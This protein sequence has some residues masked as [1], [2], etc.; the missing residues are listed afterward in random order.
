MLPTF[1]GFTLYALLMDLAYA[2]LFLMLA[3]FL[4]KA[5]KILQNLY[6]P[7]SLL[8]GV[9][10]LLC[11]PQ[12]LGLIQYSS[13]VSG[14]AGMLVILLFA[15][16]TLGYKGAREGSLVNQVLKVKDTFCAHLTAG[17]LQYGLGTLIGLLLVTLIWTDLNPAIGIL[18][19]AGFAG[20]HG[21]AASIGAIL[22]EAGFNGAT[23]L[24]IT[25]AT[26]GLLCGIVIGMININIAIRLRST[27]YT[28]QLHEIPEEMRTG[29]IPEGMRASLG[30]ATMSPS[31]IDPQGWHWC[32]VFL[33]GG[34]GYILNLRI[35]KIGGAGGVSL[36]AMCWAA[37]VGFIIQ[38]MLNKAN[39][40][41]YVNK[42][43]INRVGATVTDFLVFFGMVS[44]DTSIIV[45]FAGPLIVLSLFGILWTL[46]VLWIL[47]PM[48]FT[49]NWFE[50]SIYIYGMMNG[51]IATGVTLMRVIDPDQQSG[52]LE[53]YSI[54][55]VPMSWQN[56]IQV[57]V[58]PVLCASGMVLQA[59]LLGVGIGVAAIILSIATHTM[60]PWKRKYLNAEV[61]NQEMIEQKYQYSSSAS[62]ST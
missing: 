20:G 43:A 27:R 13:V 46:F 41:S 47:G 4:R 3:Q 60:H 2:S 45:A 55:Y 18:L 61:F 10:G 14:Y 17:F 59:G 52:T 44:V 38:A 25:F 26:I 34:I 15:T 49:K 24:G 57:G 23:G 51:V 62:K 48:M 32:L 1:E 58:M 16:L 11:G 37:I 35:P 36:P 31:S 42:V 54:A 7:A 8:A 39:M 50:K 40:G 9:I 28:K 29:W 5:L 33:C 53:D 6:I 22:E 21:S 19:P 30:E 12:F 56:L